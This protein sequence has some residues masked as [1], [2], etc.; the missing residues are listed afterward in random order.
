MSIEIITLDKE[1]CVIGLS[2]RKSG[3]PSSYKS[4]AKLWDIYGAEHRG[5]VANAINP[6]VDY[7]V[8]YALDT[9]KHEYIAGCAVTEI[10]ELN[11]SWDSFILP[12][13]EYVKHAQNNIDDLFKYEKD[14]KTWA[15][16]HN[17]KINSS[18]MVEVYPIGAYDNNGV[19][20]YILYPVQQTTNKHFPRARTAGARPYKIRTNNHHPRTP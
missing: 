12:T 16:T 19:E 4:L 13:G 8:N 10:I 6:L 11:D 17:I 5:K 18:Y 15:E 7:G 3:L 2:F 20:V 9:E 14:V 1:I